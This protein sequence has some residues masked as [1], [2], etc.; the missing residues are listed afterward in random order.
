[1]RERIEKFMRIVLL[2]MSIMA[3]AG[4]AALG[5]GMM[6]ISLVFCDSGPFQKCAEAG[7]M[8]LGG[9]WFC[10]ALPVPAVVALIRKKSQLGW[11]MYAYPFLMLA[12]ACVAYYIKSTISLGI[13]KIIF[14]Y[15]CL[16]LV[17]FAYV[18][19]RRISAKQDVSASEPAALP[20]V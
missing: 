4:P 16:A 10:A 5:V 20:P 1:M 11:Y 13:T 6:L 7:L 8:F 2:I 17:A 18:V 15:A 14:E 19:L 9:I 12:L 3:I